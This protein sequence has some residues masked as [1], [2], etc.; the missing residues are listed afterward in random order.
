VCFGLKELCWSI[1]KWYSLA[2]LILLLLCNSTTGMA[3]AN[4]NTHDIK[5]DGIATDTTNAHRDTA[6]VRKKHNIF[7]TLLK[8][9]SNKHPDTAFTPIMPK[10]VAKSEV[11]FLPY[12]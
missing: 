3:Q 12:K 1:K 9:V 8:A 6:T 2:L 11:P 4:Q 10:L 7:H 5:H